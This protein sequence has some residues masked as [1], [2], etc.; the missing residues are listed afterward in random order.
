[1]AVVDVAALRRAGG[2]LF[3]KAASLESTLPRP[4]ATLALRER[5]LIE[6]ACSWNVRVATAG[7]P[8][9]LQVDLPPPLREEMPW[10]LGAI[11]EGMLEVELAPD[12]SVRPSAGRR[13]AGAHFTSPEVAADVVERT[14]APIV[15][16][17][18]DVRSL[19]VCD[20]AMGS[21]VFL[22]AAAAFLAKARGVSVT[23]IVSG[24]LF[25]IDRDP[26]AVLAA[27][28]SLAH[29]GE[30]DPGALDA[31]L[32]VGNA[33]VAPEGAPAD[34]R[35][36]ALDWSVT[37]AE[38]TARGGFDAIVGNPPWVAYA[39]RAAQPIS[40][41]LHA[42]FRSR[43]AAF[44]GYRTLHGVFV[45]R[46]AR[47]LRPGGRLGL[48]V[49]T[50]MADLAGYAPV[51]RAH[52]ALAVPDVDLP[53][54]GAD[55]FDG[56]FQPAM[57]I[58]STRR[59][60]PIEPPDAE[61]PIARD[62]LDGI[63]RAI[64]DRC[65][66][67]PRVPPTCFG[68][69]GF[70]TSRGDVA[71]LAKEPDSRRSLGLR[72]GRDVRPFEVAPPSL[73]ADPRDLGGRLKD[74]QAWRDVG[75][76]VRQT[77]RYPMAARAD[78]TPF[79]NSILAVFDSPDLPIDGLLAYLNAWPIRFYHYMRFRDAR[80]GMPQIKIGHLRSLP[81]PSGRDWIA[82]LAD[83]G[84]RLA[85]RNQGIDADSQA[86]IDGLVAD[87]WELDPRERERIERFSR[88][89]GAMVGR[90]GER[91]GVRPRSSPG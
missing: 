64:L 23:E 52:D 54:Y 63:T 81:L 48:V 83:C 1:M 62:E 79:R 82:A 42:Y 39:G 91:S 68:E 17:C 34:R 20:P 65:A 28:L 80:Q 22:A 11:H 50:S 58:L 36:E 29:L 25:G 8:L 72:V 21:G 69:R 3:V 12:G 74:A 37:F 59:P 55:A 90:R 30:L 4:D 18:S 19:A 57:A 5:I 24:S 16:A 47:A 33:V 43:Y 7:S 75:G 13:R 15:R 88:E 71:K 67:H 40:P 53:D 87:A 45:S 84:R 61:W 44:A 77:A 56:V 9:G 38:P 26:L 76:Y 89:E 6:V 32:V 41:A 73:F 35:G 70:Q 85:D 66:R 2:E 86:R 60:E 46:A 10:A 51:R 78:G 14:L 49:P 27:R 31:R